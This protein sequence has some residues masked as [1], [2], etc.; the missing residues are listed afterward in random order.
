MIKISYCRLIVGFTN[1]NFFRTLLT[2]HN[3]A[4]Y[5]LQLSIRLLSIMPSFRNLGG[6]PRKYATAAEA[7]KANT[8][9]NSLRKK[10]KALPPSNSM[11]FIVFKASAFANV[12]S[13][14]PPLTGMRMAAQ[15]S[16]DQILQAQN[17]CES[18]ALER[19]QTDSPPQAQLPLVDNNKE[20]DTQKVQID[21]QESTLEE[22]ESD[23]NIAR[24][25]MEL[26]SS[27]T[28]CTMK[29]TRDSVVLM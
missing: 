19:P 13:N 23:L 1:Q 25:L 4:R 27:C 26:R 21:T 15:I 14:T 12:S 17:V 20:I 7:R 2:F 28:T 6:R 16:Q 29:E 22:E 10:R 3:I 8:L 24:I 18:S 5:L 9:N 11:E